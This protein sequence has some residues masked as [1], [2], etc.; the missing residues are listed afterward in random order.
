MDAESRH[1]SHRKM[2][3]TQ[4]DCCHHC[5]AAIC[6]SVRPVTK[7]G[8]SRAGQAEPAGEIHRTGIVLSAP[9]NRPVWKRIQSRHRI[10]RR[11]QDRGPLAADIGV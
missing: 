2:K 5:T 6:S 10:E 1:S 11:L 7:E 4:C 3:M 8:V 9:T